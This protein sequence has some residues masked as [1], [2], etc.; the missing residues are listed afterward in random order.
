MNLQ[1]KYKNY[2]MGYL[3]DGFIEALEKFEDIAQLSCQEII[4]N[5][6]VH[7]SMDREEDLPVKQVAALSPGLNKKCSC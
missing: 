5:E 2:I 3:T 4:K 6:F 1:L 7:V